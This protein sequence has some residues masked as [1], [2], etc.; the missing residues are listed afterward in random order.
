[1]GFF[2]TKPEQIPNKTR[3]KLHKIPAEIWLTV[4]TPASFLSSFGEWSFKEFLYI[5]FSLCNLNEGGILPDRYLELKTWCVYIA[6]R[7]YINNNTYG[8]CNRA[9]IK[10]KHRLYILMFAAI[11]HIQKY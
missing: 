9:T 2:R 10:Y 5:C 3:T 1:M 7:V 4:K 8:D 11:H 6:Y